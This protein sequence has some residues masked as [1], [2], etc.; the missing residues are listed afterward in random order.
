MILRLDTFWKKYWFN[1][2]LNI[3]M[4][5]ILNIEMG[6][7]HFGHCDMILING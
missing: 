7:I 2:I 1:I 4:G 3:E 6:M 5:M